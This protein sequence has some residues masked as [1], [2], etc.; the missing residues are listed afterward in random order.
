MK[1]LITALLLIISTYTY[2]QNFQFYRTS[3]ALVIHDTTSFYPV[4][5]KAVYK[6]TSS[7]TQ[8]FKFIRVL[9]NI[10]S[11][12]E[13]SICV[14]TSCFPS[15]LDT[16]PP[17]GG[18]PIPLSAGQTDTLVLDVLGLTP[19]IGM[20]VL[21]ACILSNPSVFIADTFRV[22]LQYHVGIKPIA[23]TVESFELS[24]NYPNPF[25]PSTIINFSLPRN[26]VVTLKVYNILGR[27]VAVLLQNEKLNAGGYSVDFNADNYKLSSGLYFYRIETESGI[28]T[29]KMIFSK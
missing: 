20:I 18:D 15:F 1:H 9:N 23:G 26:E 29:K 4:A 28:L 24:Q 21:K 25:N 8:N 6:N 10:P 19:G 13:S 3:P 12:W 17:F 27:E 5:L 22:Q 16:V 11:G 2:A 7:S 14:G